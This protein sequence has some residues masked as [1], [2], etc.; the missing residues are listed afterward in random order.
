MAVLRVL[1]LSDT[2]LGFDEPHRP[3]VARRRR[4]PDFFRNF[5]RA[6]EPARRGD[7]SLVVHGGDLLYRSR[8]PAEL[9]DRAFRPLRSLADEGIPIVVVPGNHERSRIPYPLLARH[10]RIHVFDTPGT[11]AFERHGLKIAIGG[12]PYASRVRHRFRRLVQETGIARTRAAA[13]LLVMHHA[14][15]GARVGPRDF[16]FRYGDDVVRARDL[17]LGLS[18]V[19]SGHIHRAQA[20]VGGLDGRP[21]AAP[22]LYPGSIERTSFAE[23]NERKGFLTLAFETEGRHRGRLLGWRFHPLP[24]RPMH[25]IALGQDVL[26]RADLGLWL[27]TRLRDLPEDSIVRLEVGAA[28]PPRAAVVLAAESLRRLAASTMNVEV[29]VPSWRLWE[30][31]GPRA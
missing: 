23:Q 13:K 19:L 22:V 21:L 11:F 3:R 1:F 26:A 18:A 2:H 25:R 12:F 14:V 30:A 28:L 15:E 9:V 27:Q 7:V 29:S 24:S 31:R 10:E 4:G 16:T 8:V 6:L 5:E 17:P 20:L